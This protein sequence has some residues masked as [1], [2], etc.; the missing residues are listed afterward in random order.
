MLK[1]YN[2][3]FYVPGTPGLPQR[4]EHL[5]S[6]SKF[7]RFV[8]DQLGAHSFDGVRDRILGLVPTPVNYKTLPP[9]HFIKTLFPQKDFDKTEEDLSGAAGQVKASAVEIEPEHKKAPLRALVFIWAPY[10]SN[11][12][13]GCT[14]PGNHDLTNPFFMPAPEKIGRFNGMVVLTTLSRNHNPRRGGF[15]GVEA[16][17]EKVLPLVDPE[18]LGAS[19]QH[20]SDVLLQ[21]RELRAEKLQ[22]KGLEVPVKL[23]ARE[24]AQS[25]WVLSALLREASSHY[26]EGVCEWPHGLLNIIVDTCKNSAATLIFTL[27]ILVYEYADPFTRTPVSARV[28][29]MAVKLGVSALGR[30]WTESFNEHPRRGTSF[31]LAETGF[32]E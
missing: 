8:A 26:G 3:A 7:A 17:A 32:P 20:A 5:S 12:A 4:A 31:P 15:I 24:F 2:K 16:Q 25:S 21:A 1:Q 11:A 18:V 29:T 22:K 19:A 13:Q 30:P 9:S 6:R 28:D 14:F 23:F 27:E 10:R